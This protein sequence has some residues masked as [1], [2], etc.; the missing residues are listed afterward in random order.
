MQSWKYAKL[1]G[2]L[3]VV[4]HLHG[5]ARPFKDHC[6]LLRSS[7]VII[8]RYLKCETSKYLLLEKNLPR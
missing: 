7:Q 5:L 3:G 4:D 6:L 2:A 8:E 1:F